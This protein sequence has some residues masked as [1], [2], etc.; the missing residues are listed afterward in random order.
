MLTRRGWAL[1]A[2]AV[3]GFGMAAWF[4]ARS[5]DAVVAPALVVLAAGWVR[6][7]RADQPELHTEVP[8]YGFSGETVTASL[9]FETATPLAA[10]VELHAADGLTVDPDAVETTVADGTVT[11]EVE[12]GDRGV[13]SVGPVE[14]VAEDVFGVW[15][16]TYSYP[17]SR[18]VVVFPTVHR[19]ADAGEL[20]AL[21]REFGATG[22]DRFEQLREY[23]RGD[24]LRDVHWKSSAK[25]P[26]ELV[27]MEFAASEDRRQ[28][29][30]LAE[31][32][33]GRTDEVAEAAAS[34]AAYLLDAGF[35]VGLTVPGD[36]V[37]PGAGPDHRTDLLAAL[38]RTQPGTVGEARR[39]GVDVLVRG[40]TDA[41]A[42]TVTLDGRTVTFDELTGDAESSDESEGGEERA[43]ASDDATALADGGRARADATGT[44][45]GDRA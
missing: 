28:V 23:E 27:V 40:A 14:V 33:G 25:R 41:E 44:F 30:L 17:V 15:R 12:L 42:V 31:A 7:K 9:D 4:S 11:F 22:R 5:L 32:D 34:V 6:V 8:E 36:R 1:A 10:R 13:H 24:P 38:A 20:A 21:H 3:G 43:S 18:D 45:G 29:E 35:A 19:L 26:G 37:E 39:E 2:V 16:T